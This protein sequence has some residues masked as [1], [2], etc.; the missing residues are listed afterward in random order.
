MPTNEIIFSH[1]SV[2]I[3][4]QNS[5]GS[6]QPL[7]FT[8]TQSVVYSDGG[9]G[10]GS[11]LAIQIRPNQLMWSYGLNTQS[12]PTHAGEVVQVLST[13]VDNMTISG[14]IRT[15]SDM[16]LIYKWFIA[17]MT[18][19]TQGLKGAPMLSNEF[20]YNETPVLM[21]YP[22]RSWSM[23]IR[24]LSL[25][26][27]TYGTDV[28]VPNWQM[29]AAVVEDENMELT[30]MMNSDIPSLV[31]NDLKSL[32]ANFGL[33]VENPFNYWNGSYQQGDINK[34][35]G[36]NT[37][38]LNSNPNNTQ[39]SDFFHTLVTQYA[40]GNVD[41][42]ASN[43]AYSTPYTS[44]PDISNQVSVAAGSSSGG[45]N[46]SLGG[47]LNSILPPAVGGTPPSG[48]VWAP[49]VTQLY[50]P[51]L[52]QG[53]RSKT[54]GV[55]IH[56][57][58]GT[59][60][61]TLSWFGAGNGPGGSGDIGAHFEIGGNNDGPIVQMVPLNRIAFHAGDANAYTIGVEHVG[62]GG[63]EPASDWLQT[64]YDVIGSSASLVGWILKQYNLGPPNVSLTNPSVGN[65][66]PHSC[67]GASWGGHPLC[68]GENFPWTQW[69]AACLAA[70]QAA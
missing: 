31:Q 42:T 32:D 13:Y 16:E 53:P 69:T 27:L 65:V 12:Y 49:G 21:Q 59:Y 11:Q 61:G 4:Q 35:L 29:E 47:A 50:T 7:G 8:A 66:W 63:S 37:P 46:T 25:P 1:P 41:L 18:Q 62:L 9:F 19:A 51:H 33:G 36:G 58:A 26:T 17:Y 23:Y 6:L 57:N 64:N 34:F 55:V 68:P 40:T 60:P 48:S 38:V 28:V 56:V 3:Q 43:T 2:R 20:R 54:S 70:Y 39:L 15:Y 24:P 10:A 67:G 5:E 52:D 22:H 30:M 14:D 45:T 44:N